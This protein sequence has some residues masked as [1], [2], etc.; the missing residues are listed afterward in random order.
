[1]RPPK[2]ICRQL[3]AVHKWL[4]LAWHGKDSD[5]GLNDGSYAIVQLYHISNAG[6][7]DRPNTFWQPWNPADHYFGPIYNTDGGTEPDWDQTQ[8]VPIYAANL[9][10]FDVGLKTVHTG[11]I[12]SIVKDWMGDT[13]EKR[14]RQR[15]QMNRE[16]ENR[17]DDLTREMG[18]HLWHEANKSDS[19]SVDVPWQ[20]AR[21]DMEKAMRKKELAEEQLRHYYDVEG[22]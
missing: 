4:R 6:T 3:A 11:E 18:D 10:D 5:L 12:I 7:Y 21:A 2:D 17:A 15:L 14:K 22:M 8:R 20:F 9:I 19:T 16:V 1:M 13:A